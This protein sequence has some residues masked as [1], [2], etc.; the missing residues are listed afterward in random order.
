MKPKKLEFIV[1][2]TLLEDRSDLASILKM[3]ELLRGH[4]LVF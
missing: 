2:L 4:Y 1:P 3:A